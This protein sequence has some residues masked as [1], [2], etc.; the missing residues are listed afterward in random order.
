MYQVGGAGYLLLAIHDRTAH[1][2]L[3]R[4]MTRRVRFYRCVMIGDVEGDL[5][6]NAGILPCYSLP[7]EELILV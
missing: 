1:T 2:H 3:A 7:F 4:S 6:V 5:S